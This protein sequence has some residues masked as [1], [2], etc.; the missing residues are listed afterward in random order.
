[1]LAKK[2]EAEAAA[3]QELHNQAE[4]E[5]QEWYARHE[6]QLTQTKGLNR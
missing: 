3:L 5:L 6:E 2:D 4:V 1:M